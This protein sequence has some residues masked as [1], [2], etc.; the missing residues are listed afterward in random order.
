MD[1]IGCV[2]SRVGEYKIR[3]YALIIGGQA[4]RCSHR[5]WS[6]PN[7]LLCLNHALH[8]VLRR[9][10]TRLAT[11]VA[12]TATK[13]AYAG[14]SDEVVGLRYSCSTTVG[15]MEPRH[16]PTTRNPLPPSRKIQ[17]C[18]LPGLGLY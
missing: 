18:F 4:L 2:V 5:L 1:G 10:P 17:S 8:R 7:E 15:C 12:A 9:R 6:H 16:N 14:C 3:P 11:K 13:P